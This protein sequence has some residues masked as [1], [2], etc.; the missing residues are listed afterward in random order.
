MTIGR[1]VILEEITFTESACE[2]N[3]GRRFSHHALDLPARLQTLAERRR[4][5]MDRGDTARIMLKT[6]SISSRVIMAT[7]PSRVG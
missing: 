2:M 5:F 4:F 6:C 7:I 1:H 3:Q